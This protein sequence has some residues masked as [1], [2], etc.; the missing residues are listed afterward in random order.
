MKRFVFKSLLAAMAVSVFSVSAVAQVS[1]RTI[2]LATANPKGHPITQGGEKFIE[3]VAAKSGGKIKVNFFPGGV[4]GS[5]Q[6][7]ASSMQ[8]CTVDMNIGNS[9]ILAAQEPSFAIFDFPFMIT[10]GLEADKVLDGPFG[11]KMH[12]KLEAKGLVGLSYMEL[13]FRSITNSKRPL[14]KVDDIAGLKLRVIG[15]PIHLDWGNAIGANAVAMAFGE[16]YGALESKA[17][18][19]QENPYTVIEANKFFEVQKHLAV[20]NHLYNPQSV[21]IS[22]KTWDTFSAEEKKIFQD[23]AQEAAVFQRV[24]TRKQAGEALASLKAKGMAVTEF[25]GPEILKFAEKVKPVIVK[26]TGLVGAETVTD[27]LKAL[28]AAR[29]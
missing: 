18:D 17:I 20:T 24:V 5:D 7:V 28:E 21:V 26:Y 9:G 2:R 3:I 1:E 6:Q 29:K 4:L 16:V 11:K 19:G 8:G 15:S 25:S 27:Y 13:G 22:K 10:N 23:A 12:T 14:T